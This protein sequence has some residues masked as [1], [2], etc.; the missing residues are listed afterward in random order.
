MLTNRLILEPLH[1]DDA[2]FILELV[3]T[4]GWLQFIGNRNVNDLDDAQNYI[5]RILNNINVKYW[6]VRDQKKSLPIGIITFIKRDYLLYHDIGFAFLP[7]YQQNGYAYEASL[8]VLKTLQKENAHPHLLATT[9]PNNVQ[10]IRLLEK[11]GF[12][13]QEVIEVGND[14]LSVYQLQPSVLPME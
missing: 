2:A 9:I 8:A 1:L 3:N 7:Q 4:Q 10:S 12:R 14:K 6:V 13:F 11:L 5:Q